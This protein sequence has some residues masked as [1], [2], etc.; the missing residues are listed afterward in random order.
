MSCS[1]DTRVAGASMADLSRDEY[2]GRYG[3]TTRRPVGDVVSLNI[4][5]EGILQDAAGNTARTP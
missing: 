3:P 5:F 1:S 2:A 4:S